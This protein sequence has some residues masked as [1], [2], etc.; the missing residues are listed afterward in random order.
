MNEV[1][2]GCKNLF[3]K[4]C[5]SVCIEE[6]AAASEKTTGLSS[7]SCSL[8]GQPG[9]ILLSDWSIRLSIGFEQLLLVH[10]EH[11]E[12]DENQGSK[13]GE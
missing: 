9:K 3:V 4:P 7:K 1:G 11:E 6:P 12:A 5:K 2:V 8:I 13:E 10:P